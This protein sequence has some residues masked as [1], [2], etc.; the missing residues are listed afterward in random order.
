[1]Q[2]SAG[3]VS[4]PFWYIEAKKTAKYLIEYKDTKEIKDI[5]VK[6]KKILILLLRL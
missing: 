2:Y 4:R 6:L 1:M 3:M 5:V